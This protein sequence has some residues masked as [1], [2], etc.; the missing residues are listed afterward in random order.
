MEEEV[1]V[2]KT[3]P[4]SAISTNS[5]SL[6]THPDIISHYRIALFHQ[7]APTM[8]SKIEHQ[9]DLSGVGAWTKDSTT[10]QYDR[11]GSA[12]LQKDLEAIKGTETVTSS[13]SALASPK[14]WNSTFPLHFWHGDGPSS[15]RARRSH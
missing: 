2:Y 1:S 7:L 5:S 4:I 6:P 9:D 12:M 14:P 3:S 8:Q 10:T 15:N 13:A 11:S